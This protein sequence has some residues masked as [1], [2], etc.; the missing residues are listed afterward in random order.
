MRDTAAA[1]IIIAFVGALAVW[2]G[3]AAGDQSRRDFE[4][5]CAAVNGKATWNGRNWECLK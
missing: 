5:A 4:K 2:I 3:T 1:I